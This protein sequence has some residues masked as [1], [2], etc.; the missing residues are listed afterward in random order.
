MASTGKLLM[1]KELLSLE[2]HAA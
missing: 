2:F 1:N